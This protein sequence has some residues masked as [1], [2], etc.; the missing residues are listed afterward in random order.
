MISGVF[1][2]VS[3]M[4]LREAKALAR[5][6]WPSWVFNSLRVLPLKESEDCAISKPL[7]VARSNVLEKIPNSVFKCVSPMKVTALEF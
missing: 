4:S 1:L 2:T 5:S 3:E 7:L 6:P